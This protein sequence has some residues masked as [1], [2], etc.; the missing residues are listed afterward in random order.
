VSRSTGPNE[1]I[2]AG[3]RPPGTP[4][5]TTFRKE[6]VAAKELGGRGELAGEFLT[7]DPAARGEV[8]VQKGGA[9]E[10]AVRELSEEVEKEPLPVEQR[11]QIRRFHELILGEGDTGVRAEK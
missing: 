9:V 10:Q 7:E 3:P 5:A 8:T 4:E 11:E 2:G 1:G 6:R